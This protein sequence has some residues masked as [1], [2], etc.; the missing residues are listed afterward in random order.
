MPPG[1]TIE[2]LPDTD[3]FARRVADWMLDIALTNK[4]PFAIALSGGSTPREV[5]DLFATP[6]YRDRFPW[7]RAH[8]FWGDERFVPHENSRSNYGMAW[9]TFLSRVPLPRANI[10]AVPTEEV[11]AQ[12]AAAEYERRL[13][14]FHGRATLESAEPLFGINLLGLGEDGHF[15]SLF[16]GAG[17]LDERQRWV[18]A[19]TDPQSEP[20]ITLTYPALESSRN[21]AFLV[22]GEAK[23]KI[24]QRLLAGDAALPASRFHPV[25]RLHLFA[26]TAAAGTG[27]SKSGISPGTNAA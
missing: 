4:E 20:R 5:Y 8:W 27:A 12:A 26:D 16:P 13:K 23:A 1:P 24:L 22:T 9:K 2:V 11:S 10:H 7:A 14:T 3:S 25:G 19:T 15:A 21:A 6:A 17:A 18:V